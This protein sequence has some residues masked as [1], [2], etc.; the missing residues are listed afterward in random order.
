MDR[1]RLQKTDWYRIIWNGRMLSL[2]HHLWPAGID[3]NFYQIW[4]RSW[5]E[6][7]SAE[8]WPA[9]ELRIRIEHFVRYVTSNDLENFKILNDDDSYRLGTLFESSLCVRCH[10]TYVICHHSFR[11]KQFQFYFPFYLHFEAP[12]PDVHLRSEHFRI[13]RAL[14]KGGN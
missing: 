5:P 11:P 2:C 1:P 9:L 10:M 4:S 7:W 14:R 8:I 12:I 13:L 3:K 6:I